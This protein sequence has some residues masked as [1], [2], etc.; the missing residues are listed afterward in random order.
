MIPNRP[1][2][3]GDVET[4]DYPRATIE[5]VRF[6]AS[7]NAAHPPTERPLVYSLLHTG[8]VLRAVGL[9]P[10]YLH[11]VYT[12]LRI[13]HD[14]PDVDLITGAHLAAVSD[15]SGFFIETLLATHRWTVRDIITWSTVHT[16][17][18]LADCQDVG[19]TLP[20]LGV[21]VRSDQMPDASQVEM[22]KALQM[23]S[24]SSA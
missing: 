15:L 14:S 8:Y 21:L 3:N 10:S 11:E 5:R 19:F 23:G 6:A 9:T 13:T 7:W 4:M 1:P 20:E 18:H 17:D 24:A 22:L 12:A 16:S 2:F